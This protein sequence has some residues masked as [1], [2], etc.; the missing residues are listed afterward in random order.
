MELMKK[1]PFRCE[2]KLY[3]IRILFGKNTMNVVAFYKNHP[4]NGFRHHIQISKNMDPVR[5]I[6]TDVLKEL[7]ELAK[8]DII[9]DR[10]ESMI[11]SSKNE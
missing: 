4:A 5:L 3:E 11:I 10:W 6:K 1:I 2:D 8:K 7:V 9:K